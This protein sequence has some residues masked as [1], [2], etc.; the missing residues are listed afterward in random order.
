MRDLWRSVSSTTTTDGRRTTEQRSSD[1]PKRQTDRRAQHVHVRP[2]VCGDTQQCGRTQRQPHSLPNRDQRHHRL[3]CWLVRAFCTVCARYD[4]YSTI[5][6][7]IKMYYIIMH[8]LRNA[9]WRTKHSIHAHAER[10]STRARNKTRKTHRRAHTNSNSIAGGDYLRNLVHQESALAHKIRQC[11][12][13]MAD[14]ACYRSKTYTLG[15]SYALLRA[16]LRRC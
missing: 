5:N 11:L 16:H 9:V 7:H 2:F 8:G 10:E 14:N 3:A 1:G 12:A 6:I 15:I 13:T 4:T